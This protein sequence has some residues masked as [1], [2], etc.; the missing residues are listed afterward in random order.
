MNEA[1]A[2]QVTAA[3][4]E[5]ST[6]LSAN[7]GSG[8]T[9]VLT[10]RVA[11]L[12]LQGVPPERILCLTYTKAAAMEMQNRLFDRLGAWAMKA[13]A[14]LRATLEEVGVDPASLT[15][16]LLRRARTLFAR[17]IETPGGLKIQTIHSF[18]ASVLRRFPLEAGVSPGFTEIDERVQGRL[19]ADLL[20]DMARDPARRGAIDAVVPFLGDEGGLMS[21]AR[22]VAGSADALRDPL[23]RAGVCAALGIDP[24]LTED[25]I[26][27]SVLTGEERDVCDAIRAQLDPGNRQQGK[28]CRVLGAIPWEEMTLDALKLLEDVCL[29]GEKA[30]EPFSAKGEKI[31]NAAVRAAVGPEIMAA[32]AELTHRVEAARPL[33]LNLL[34]ARKTHALHVF[35]AAFL[36]A[37]AEAKTARGWL[38]FDD[39]ISRTRDLLAAPGIAQWVLFRLD[40]G[41]DHI[42]V[43]EAQD[44][45]PAQWEIVKR[46]AEDFAAGAGARAEVR[47]TIFVVGDKKQSIYS[48]QGADPEGFDRMRDHFDERLRGIGA[49]LQSRELKYSFRSARPILD[50]VD[51]VCAEEM[52]TAAGGAIE[53]KAFFHQKPGRVD[54]WPVVPPADRAEDPEWH[55]PQ[56]LV[57]EDHHYSLL[58]G[59][60]ADRLHAMIH[61]ERPVIE[62]GKQRRPVEAGDILILVRRRSPLFR[63]IIGAIKRRGLPIAGVDRSE[64]T[65]PLAVRDLL[66]LL[67]FLATPEDDLSLACV[68]RSPIGG[69]SEDDLFRLAHGRK[70]YLWQ[71][72][73]RRAG[74]RDDWLAT[75]AMLSD[76]LDAADFRRPYDLLERALIR[77]GARLRLA[78]RL[79]PEAEDGI[80]A[81]L[82]QALAYERMEVPSLTGFIGWLE[83]GEVTVKRDL[84]QARGQIRVMTVHGAKGLEAPVVILPDTGEWPSRNGGAQ[85]VRDRSGTL[86]W[87]T[88]RAETAEPVRAALEERQ[89][90]QT[91]ERNRLLYV[92]LTRAES[93]L[94]VAAAGRARSDATP[95]WYQAVEDGLTRLGAGPLSIPELDG[96]GLRLEAGAFRQEAPSAAGPAPGPPVRL[97]DW[98][99]RPAPAAPRDRPALS[100]SALGGEKALSPAEGTVAPGR[101]DALRRGRL[102]HLLLEHL[103]NVPPP[104]WRDAAPGIAALEAPDVSLAELA[105]ALA[106]AEAVLTAPALAHVFAPGTLAEVELCGPGEALGRPLLGAIDRLIVAPDRVLAVDFKTNA[107]VPATAESV[108]EGI[109]RQMGAYAGMLEAI[110]PGRP[111]ETAILWSRTA[112]LMP[113]PRALTSAAL[114]RA[115]ADGD[116]TVAGAA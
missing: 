91:E 80:D 114:A 67:R 95:T 52:P 30:N 53:H 51:T 8:K 92:A 49:P 77:H 48:F 99:H 110:Y 96:D 9:R 39:L 64:L 62:V 12:L 13:E 69:W 3:D 45:S 65:T 42:L 21:F 102:V 72:L 26:L 107:E 70:G 76:L 16:D 37:Y 113:L 38:D 32:F 86:H 115:A 63:Q 61:E 6:W 104:A 59:A 103:P 101:A 11:R 10:D 58:A 56:D 97:P 57:G 116:G 106:E 60:I 83:A 34:A 14:D 108:P 98:V 22:A 41:I 15:P 18:C 94:I 105:D 81:M 29:S 68:L 25:A 5:V 100:P 2:A 35:A 17:A 33:R 73:R 27:A 23:D 20:D 46:L 50:L 19:I 75:R 36:P 93:W 78:A 4:P 66:A 82:S 90:R 55:D 85:L 40:G 43:D 88:S 74:E 54:L 112:R 7:A 31:G 44:T 79:G 28:L 84:A 109:L 1:S 89:A 47:R 71:A 24:G 111:V 87:A